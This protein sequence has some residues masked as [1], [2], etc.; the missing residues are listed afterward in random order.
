MRLTSRAVV[1]R[2]RRLPIPR[3]LLPRLRRLNGHAG[4]RARFPALAHQ[5]NTPAEDQHTTV[6]KFQIINKTTI[7]SLDLTRRKPGSFSVPG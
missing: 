2:Q 5:E 3:R 1:R 6:Q 7:P 4:I